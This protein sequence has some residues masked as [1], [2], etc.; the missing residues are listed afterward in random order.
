MYSVVI[1]ED[2]SIIRE[3]LSRLIDWQAFGCEVAFLAEDGLCAL[4]YIQDHPVDILI[5]D[6]KMPRMSGLDLIK[7]AREINED[8]VTFLVSGYGDFEYAKSAIQYNVSGYVLKPLEEEQLGE[9]ILKAVSI[10]EKRAQRNAVEQDAQKVGL[11]NMAMAREKLFTRVFYSRVKLET[12]PDLLMALNLDDKTLYGVYL[13]EVTGGIPEETKELLA[14]SFEQMVLVEIRP[15]LW[16]LVVFG[17]DETEMGKNFG[18]FKS[19]LLKH[20]CRKSVIGVG[21]GMIYQ[22]LQGLRKSF[23][24]AVV[25]FNLRRSNTF[26]LRSGE[27]KITG[28][29][30]KERC[31]KIVNF[32]I[33]GREGLATY[34]DLVEEELLLSGTRCIENTNV[35]LG[36]VYARIVNT[37]LSREDYV[38]ADA[39]IK[40]Y[41]RYEKAINAIEIRRKIRI[42]EEL[43][44]EVSSLFEVSAKGKWA[45]EINMAIAYIEKNYYKRTMDVGEIADHVG[46]SSRYFSMIFKEKVGKSVMKY[47]IEYRVN[48]AKQ[49]LM[50]KDL[51]AYQVAEMVG[52]D[53]YPYFSTL[54]RKVTGENPGTYSE[55]MRAMNSDAH[56]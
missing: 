5:T 30:L 16:A 41:S 22:N 2:E 56:L 8:I 26:M 12:E 36:G 11:K 17:S 55:R 3:G 43:L 4:G 31:D 53:S 40:L 38:D 50:D 46:M 10:L 37:L 14:Y 6:I 7:N 52:Y 9:L 21:S 49:L 1:A 35:L 48:I 25:N 45:K 29:D 42:L 54:F 13:F 18:S 15:D 24:E 32:V 20:H 47:L 44:E 19:M 34:L 51:K 39:L 33:Q 27:D 28:V 23:E